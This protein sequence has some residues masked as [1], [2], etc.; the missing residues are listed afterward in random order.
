LKA[1]DKSLVKLVWLIMNH[2]DDHF[3]N[4]KHNRQSSRSFSTLLE[5]VC[6][7]HISISGCI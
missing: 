5:G 3:H 1:E 4:T 7:I 2:S 6:D